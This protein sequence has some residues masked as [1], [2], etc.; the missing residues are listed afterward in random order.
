M[1]TLMIRSLDEDVKAGLRVLAAHRGVSM[2]QHARD[3]LAQAVRGAAPTEPFVDRVRR[4]FAG[5]TIEALPIPKRQAP[6]L[7]PGGRDK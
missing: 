2:E 1:A 5:T 6:R 3:L 4:R 7:P